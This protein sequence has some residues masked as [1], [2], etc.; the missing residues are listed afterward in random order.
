VGT[1]PNGGR[2]RASTDMKKRSHPRGVRWMVGLEIAAVTASTG[3]TGW[4]TQPRRPDLI[5]RLRI[6]R[7]MDSAPEGG[8]N[9]TTAEVTHTPAE[10]LEPEHNWPAEL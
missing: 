8:V 4:S 9:A 1:S 10:S 6:E 2:A 5:G 7:S 3:S